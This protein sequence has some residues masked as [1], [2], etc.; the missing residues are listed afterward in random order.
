MPNTYLLIRAYRKKMLTHAYSS[1]LYLLQFYSLFQMMKIR[2]A[3]VRFTYQK[4]CLIDVFGF[5]VGIFD[6]FGEYQI[7]FEE[8]NVSIFGFFND[9]FLIDHLKAAKKRPQN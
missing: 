6:F 1:F 9:L 8:E 3:I 2:E 4:F 7:Q 5:S